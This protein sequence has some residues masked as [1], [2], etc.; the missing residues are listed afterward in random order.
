MNKLMIIGN[1][2]KDPELRT[3]QNGI[4]VCSFNVAVNRRLGANAEHPEADFFRVTAWR[5][6]GQNCHLY[7]TKGKK[8]AVV[9]SVSASAYMG[10][11]GKPRASLEITAD[12][13]EFLSPRNDADAKEEAYVKQEREA[14][15]QEPVQASMVK[16]DAGFVVVN[17]DDDLPF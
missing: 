7:L 3:T 5:Q 14:I 17:D 12:D 8:V 10:S 4:P 15:Q 6:L 13:V 2:T 9:G 11:D 16:K 1:V